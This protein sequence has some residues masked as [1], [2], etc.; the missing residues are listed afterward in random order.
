M[1]LLLQSAKKLGRR[2]RAMELNDA[3]FAS[4]HELIRNPESSSVP[5]DHEDALIR[6]GLA[7]HWAGRVTVTGAGRRA[8]FGNDAGGAQETHRDP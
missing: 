2:K 6:L 8:A 5:K 4:L 7:S 3:L 1:P